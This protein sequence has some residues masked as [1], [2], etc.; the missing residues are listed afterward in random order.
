MAESCR[1]CRYWKRD[2]EE[3]RRYPPVPIEYYVTW[4][5]ERKGYTESETRSFST[6]PE[7]GRD[8]W[9]GEYARAHPEEAA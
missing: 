4:E 9:C 6:W 7:V 1:T 2:G 8:D 3:C 5:N